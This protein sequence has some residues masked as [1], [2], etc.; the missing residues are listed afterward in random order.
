MSL[1][2]DG[3][4]VNGTATIPLPRVSVTTDGKLEGFSDSVND[5]G[6]GGG[7]GGSDATQNGSTAH[8]SGNVKVF[9]GDADKVALGRSM[10]IGAVMAMWLY[11]L[12]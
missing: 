6:G 5:D 2:A 9:S 1:G 12:H 8:G 3:L 10:L 11:Y 7:G 4:V